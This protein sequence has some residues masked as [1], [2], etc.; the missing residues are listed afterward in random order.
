MKLEIA[1]QRDKKKYY[2]FHDDHRHTTDEC[3]QLKDK[4]ER[5]IHQGNLRRF[6]KIEGMQDKTKDKT[7]GAEGHK[8]NG[9]R[10][11]RAVSLENVFSINMES[12]SKDPFTFGPKDY[13]NIKRLHSDSIVINILLNRYMVQ[14]VLID[15]GNLVNLITLEVYKNL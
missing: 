13:E 6:A 5:L 3:Q 2:H 8:D 4:I 11:A 15:T 7:G 10:I 14:R 12:F 1:N 9:K